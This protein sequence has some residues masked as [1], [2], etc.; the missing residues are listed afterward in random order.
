MKDV[1]A[2][3]AG[4]DEQPG[5]KPSPVPLELDGQYKCEYTAFKTG[6]YEIQIS[7]GRGGGGYIDLIEGEDPEPS[8]DVH[9][10][11]FR[12]SD[13]GTTPQLFQL[14]VE[15]GETN[16]KASTA[17]GDAITASTAGSIGTFLITAKDSF[18][19]RRPGGEAVT[20]LMRYWS[21][22]STYF[23]EQDPS[24]LPQTGRVIDNNDGSYAVT[25]RITKAGLYQHAIS[26]VAAVGAGSPVF[27]HVSSDVADA[28]RTYV[29]GTL[30]SLET[31]KPSTIYIQTRDKYGNAPRYTNEV[32]HRGVVTAGC[33]RG[34][35]A[36]G[37]GLERGRG[38]VSGAA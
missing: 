38:H 8:N 1:G 7:V 28:T 20:S 2:L 18:Q 35:G 29:Y 6:H 32:G 33:A 25:Y 4:K 3:G 24:A 23:G 36:W 27:L 37:L 12:P 15:P 19:N 9:E 22:T 14:I 11:V 31:G 34:D 26:L 21:N 10:Y 30:L 16:A 5:L 13:K 17:V